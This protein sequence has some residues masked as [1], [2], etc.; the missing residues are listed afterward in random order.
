MICPQGSWGN[1]WASLSRYP[2]KS[3]S[4]EAKEPYT[5]SIQRPQSRS[6]RSQKVPLRARTKLNNPPLD[7]PVTN[8]ARC[9]IQAN[10]SQPCIVC[11]VRQNCRTGLHTRVYLP[12]NTS[13]TF[14]CIASYHK[15]FPRVCKMN[16][17]HPADSR[18]RVHRRLIEIPSAIYETGLR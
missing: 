11:P 18:I 13:F 1:G 3:N 8:P 16:S 10:P 2:Q 14:S 9:V 12:T 6:R 4:L 17:A 15:H 7:R 5:G